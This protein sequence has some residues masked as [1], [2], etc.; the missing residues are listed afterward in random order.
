MTIERVVD[1]HIE[2]YLRHLRAERGLSP[3]TLAAYRGDLEQ[4]A[5]LTGRGGADLRWDK[6]GERDLERFSLALQER[7]YADTS[8]ARKVAAVRSLFR[9]LAEEELVEHNPAERIQTRRPSRALPSVLSE[10]E[11][12][13]ILRAASEQEGAEALRDRAMLEITYAAGLRVSEVVGPTGLRLNSLHLE[14]GEVRVLGKGSKERI[15]PV[16]PGVAR[17]VGRYVRDARPVLL[18][19]SRARGT[20]DALFLNARGRALTRQGYWLVLKRCAARAGVESRVSPHTLRHSFATHLLSGGAS[21]RHVQELLGH[22]TIATTQIYTHLTDG[23]VLEA[24]DA[25]HPRA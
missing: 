1:E 20:T 17:L 12:V 6:L 22:A 2:A 10:E 18:A 16:Y 13:A 25:A 7:R 5:E 23:Q 3:N 15:V 21:L 24:Y 19:H 14:D 9:F 4:F 8:R 11:V